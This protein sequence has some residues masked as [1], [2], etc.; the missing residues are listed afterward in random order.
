MSETTPTP[1]RVPFATAVPDVF[2]DARIVV[3]DD[4]PGN[5]VLL[6]HVLR[7]AGAG[8]VVC[9]TDAQEALAACE[10]V[11]PD[12]ILLDLHMPDVNGLTVM[13]RLLQFVPDDVF[14]PVVMLT[15]DMAPEARRAALAAGAKDFLTKPFDFTEV[16]LRVRNLLETN[17]LYQRLHTHNVQLRAELDI[18][19]AAERQQLD[20]RE[21]RERRVNEVLTGD[22][23]TVVFQPIVD[24]VTGTTVGAEAL[25]RFTIDPPRPPSDWF[26]EATAIGRGVELELAA[27]EC[28]LRHL[29][30]LPSGV[31]L[32][33]NAAPA[34]AC[35]PR[36]ARVLADTGANASRLV[37]ELT[38]HQRVDDYAPLQH[39]LDGLRELGV[40]IA[41]DDTGAGYA[42][43]NHILRLG[44]DILKLDTDITRGIDDDP[45][46]RSLAAALVAFADDTGAHLI[47]EGIETAGEL[48]ALHQLGIVWAQGYYLGRPSPL[49]LRQR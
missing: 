9:F 38:E 20:A 24:I 22:K 49:P 30:D 39:A 45:V 3:I 28:A 4:T 5:L 29:H 42:S 17:A 26:A 2:A 21:R 16:V 14:L 36:L 27:I 33:L 43:L 41:V 6:E 35:S 46:R 12:L 32:S 34:T 13:E 18:H 48:A 31:F 10:A 37:L 23:L 19:A 1:G 15:A 44:A 40:R 25:A 47:A 8:T 11:R 7:D